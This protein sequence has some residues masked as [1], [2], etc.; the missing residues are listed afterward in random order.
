M[1]EREVGR[2]P[3]VDELGRCVGIVTRRDLLRV[4]LRPDDEIR[5]E[6][7]HRV[8]PETLCMDPARLPVRVKDG[9]VT[10]EGRVERKGMLPLIASIIMEV[11]GVVDVVMRTTFEQDDTVHLWAEA[12]W[13]PARTRSA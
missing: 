10:V 11:D 1:T 13:P 5:E 7:E 3:V 9:V 2:L 6:I 4:Y 12:V 8:V